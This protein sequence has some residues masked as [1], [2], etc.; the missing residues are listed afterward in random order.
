[1]N[2]KS[3]AILSFL[4]RLALVENNKSETNGNRISSGNSNNIS[5]RN[6]EERNNN[7]VKKRPIESEK[8]LKTEFGIHI[9]ELEKYI[10]DKKGSIESGNSDP[11]IV[12]SGSTTEFF[13]DYELIDTIVWPQEFIEEY[14][15]SPQS[16]H[17]T[18]VLV[19]T[20]T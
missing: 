20:R 8:G 11:Q 4:L 12:S 5:D 19:A 1:M 15:H 3:C 10:I 13:I 6:Y 18:Y 9:K 14:L 2:R 17:P 16:Q 7:K